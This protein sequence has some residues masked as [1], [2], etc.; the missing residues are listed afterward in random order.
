MRLK[1]C[2]LMVAFFWLF[3][4]MMSAGGALKGNA[5]VCEIVADKS[6]A[7]I[8]A[9]IDRT[10]ARGGGVVFLPA[11][12]Y[13]LEAGLKMRRNIILRGEGRATLLRRSPFVETA[14][15][16][17]ALKGAADIR[18]KD[19]RGFKAGAEVALWDAKQRQGANPVICDITRVTNV[20][21]NRIFLADALA[22]DYLASRQAVLFNAFPVIFGRDVESVIVENL[23]VDGARAPGNESPANGECEGI[24]FTDCRNCKVLDC[25][26]YSCGGF[27]ISDSGGE[28][29]AFRG[30][31]SYSNTWHGFHL[32]LGKKA[33]SRRCTIENCYAH[34][35]G[36]IG[37]YLCWRASEN[38]IRGNHLTDNKLNGLLIGPFD[39]RNLIVNNII[40]NNGESGILV[41]RRAHPGRSNMFIGNILCDNGQP[42]LTPA[43]KIESPQEG[44]YE[45]FLFARNMIIETR[46]VEN[47]EASAFFID[48]QTDHIVIADN[49]LQGNWK[50]LAEDHSRGGNNTIKE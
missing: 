24:Q 11:G 47:P 18:V 25:T 20:E 50:S 23:A 35:N 5:A 27:G 44:Q 3:Y 21:G 14:L 7:A 22:A 43:I 46:A 19:P 36:W 29:V 37:I 31:E 41:A 16:A 38:I 17:D 42:G 4:G 9:A 10:A 39:D 30:C 28:N 34:H 15:M 2:I 48:E 8:Q 26:V 49:Y 33:G 13:Y 45:Y 1:S 12:E 6:G 40:S 32:G